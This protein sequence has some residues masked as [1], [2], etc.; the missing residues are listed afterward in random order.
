M[1]ARDFHFADHA[2][3]FDA[4][5]SA[6]IPGYDRLRWWITQLSRRFVREGTRVIDVGC[7]TGSTLK[8]IHDLNRA[9][10]PAVGYVG[11][12]ICDAFCSQWKQLECDTLQFQ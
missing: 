2:A 9:S 11:I 6:S 8:Q 7:S 5:I 4:H 1:T 3:G 12:D 10:R